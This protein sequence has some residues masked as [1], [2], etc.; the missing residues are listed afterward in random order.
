MNVIQNRESFA[1]QYSLKYAKSRRSIRPIARDLFDREYFGLIDL[2]GI[3]NQ[4]TRII[5][6]NKRFK[7]PMHFL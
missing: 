1:K 4:S 5:R 2:L 6:N 3:N 7:N